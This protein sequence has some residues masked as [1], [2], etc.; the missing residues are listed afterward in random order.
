[1]KKIVSLLAIALL[2]FSAQLPA[3]WDVLP[4]VNIR[5]IASDG[6]AIY[7]LFYNPNANLKEVFFSTDYGA[8]W[9]PISLNP[10]NISQKKFWLH[11]FDYCQNHLFFATDIGVVVYQLSTG[12]CSWLGPAITHPAL[13][14]SVAKSATQPGHFVVGAAVDDWQQG[15]FLTNFNPAT[16]TVSPWL[17]YGLTAGSRVWLDP[18]QPDSVIYASGYQADAQ[19]DYVKIGSTPWRYLDP[20]NSQRRK[21]LSAEIYQGQSYLFGN[22]WYSTDHSQTFQRL[23]C[24]EASALI[25]GPDGVF[26]V[27]RTGHDYSIPLSNKESFPTNELLVGTVTALSRTHCYADFPINQL[28]VVGPYLFALDYEGR[29]LRQ[30]TQHAQQAVADFVLFNLTLDL[31][32]PNAGAI[33]LEPPVLFQWQDLGLQYELVISYDP[34][35]S[36]EVYHHHEINAASKSVSAE[37]L[38]PNN[39]YYW[40][41]RGYSAGNFTAWAN[42]GS[43]STSARTAVDTATFFPAQFQLT[44][45][46]PNPFNS[47]TTFS[48]FLPE[49]SA[50]ELNIFDLTGQLIANPFTGS[51]SAGWQKLTWRPTALPSG[52]YFCQFR[53]NNTINARQ[54]IILL[55]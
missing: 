43:F 19:G 46:Y 49:K 11:D 41:L 39:I 14:V 30:T 23:G 32:Q 22:E 34:D 33:N 37:F 53:I 29:L 42:G 8:S 40:R 21:F 15:L 2:A 28:L 35:F 55:K 13:A 7:A 38:K 9:Q 1:M 16:Q 3:A 48:F 31:W 54:K 4:F 10:A 52:T 17:D 6:E 18:L 44:G 25:H 24:N 26:Y 27:A 47:T 36:E 45:N 51:L 50:V 12:A 5:Q 20:S